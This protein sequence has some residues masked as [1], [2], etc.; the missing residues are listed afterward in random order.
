VPELSAHSRLSPTPSISKLDT[1]LKPNLQ[2]ATPHKQP[3]TDHIA[4]GR[5]NYNTVISP[6][7]RFQNRASDR[8]TRQR[9]KAHNR[10][11]GSIVPTIDIRITQ[12]SHTNRRETNITPR[13][14]AEDDCVDNRQCFNGHGVG[15][16]GRR[17]ERGGEPEGK[18]CSAA[19]SKSGDHA[20]EATEFIG[21]E[22]G[23]P[24]ADA[25][26]C[27]KDGEE[28]VGEGWAE[29]AG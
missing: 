20:I 19:D 10:V 7:T 13:S 28:L 26:P 25:A 22:T 14:E 29:D 1:N 9:T 2:S 21:E 23:D 3:T 5:P 4:H 8:D 18:R 17:E 15:W 6:A 27:V 16:G 12:L 24:T 11:A